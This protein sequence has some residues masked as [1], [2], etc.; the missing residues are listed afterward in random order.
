MKVINLTTGIVE[1][2]GTV[3]KFDD[4]GG[5]QAFEWISSFSVQQAA[6]Q[7]GNNENVEVPDETF[8]KQLKYE[9]E[10]DEINQFA[11]DQITKF[12][13]L[14]KQNNI[15]NSGDQEKITS[16]YEFIDRVREWSNSTDPIRED[17]LEIVP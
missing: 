2:N 8:E 15:L 6:L 7:S 13:P 12:Y 17:V 3:K 10:Q 4:M 9:Y 16:M 5:K 1:F 11:F 14:W